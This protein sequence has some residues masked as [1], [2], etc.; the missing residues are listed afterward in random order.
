MRRAKIPSRDELAVP[1]TRPAPDASGSS[2]FL[3]PLAV[4]DVLGMQRAAGNH[5]TSRL[6]GIQGRAGSGASMHN[7]AMPGTR[8]LQRV[9]V[10]DHV[11]LWVNG[12]MQNGKLSTLG[13]AVFV[14]YR[15]APQ[16]RAECPTAQPSIDPIDAAELAKISGDFATGFKHGN[17]DVF[18]FAG[19]L[20]DARDCHEKQTASQPSQSAVA[21]EEAA[22]MLKFYGGG[23]ESTSQTT[24]TVGPLDPKVLLAKAAKDWFNCG[25][26]SRSL[27]LELDNA[28]AR[29]KQIKH[30][31]LKRSP[32]AGKELLALLNE[33]RGRHVLLDCSFMN[34]HSWTIERIP[35]DT[36]FL[37]QGYQGQYSAFWWQGI[38]DEPASVRGATAHPEAV[39]LRERYGLG[40]PLARENVETMHGTLAQMLV[41]APAKEKQ[42]EG[43]ER[44]L[45]DAS[46]FGPPGVALWKRLP[47]FPPEPEQTVRES[48]AELIVSV[49]EVQDPDSVRK[50]LSPDV[51]PK[52]G[53]LATLVLESAFKEYSAAEKMGR[54]EG[55]KEE[56]RD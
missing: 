13:D 37:V 2:R 24:E 41:G 10:N 39:K 31:F 48:P 9:G 42:K 23:A 28:G 47:F 21:K 43:E 1:A 56:K 27:Q 6:L 25:N 29:L 50:R 52:T 46:V 7:F 26:A 17:R 53:S 12:A 35:D 22:K 55:V 16:F 54:P 38:T 34:I 51:K 11:P 14:V 20:K 30:V 5:A 19:S 4:D 44:D 8:M 36:C 33:G 45:G 18:A 40:Q 15:S 32:E 3:R 49:W